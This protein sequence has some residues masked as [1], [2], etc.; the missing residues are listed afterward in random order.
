[1]D[2]IKDTIKM[3]KR[4][5]LVLPAKLR[6]QFGLEDGSLLLTEAKD[7]EIRL[8]PAV[9]SDG[10]IFTPERRAY[11]MLINSMTQEEWDE[12]AA[13]VR[14]MGL[15]PENI[16]GIDAGHRGTLLT[17]RQWDERTRSAV[18][19]FHSEQRSA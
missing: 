13:Q 15:N 11:F 18:T 19:A 12:M 9:V 4:G 5:T 8:R 14:A 10:E 1:M 2:S 7:G 6:K 16:D 3:G 17:N